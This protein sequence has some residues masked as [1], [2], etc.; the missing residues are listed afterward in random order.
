MFT[1]QII[2]PFHVAIAAGLL[3][4]VFVTAPAQAVDQSVWLQEQIA[5]TDG[6][7]Y[8]QVGTPGSTPSQGAGKFYKTDA[9]SVWVQAQLA[10]TDGSAPY[11]GGDAEP[12]YAGAPQARAAT[13]W[14]TSNSRLSNTRFTRPMVA[15][16]EA[17][18]APHARWR[19]RLRFLHRGSR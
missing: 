18:K 13:R 14:P 5:I 10:V 8:S 11:I 16:S 7:S 2:K 3:S 9:Q 19:G 15:T 4:A 6:A 1:K 17:A 12:V